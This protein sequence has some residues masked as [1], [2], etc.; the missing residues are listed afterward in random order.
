MKQAM[1]FE[2]IGLHADV[3]ERERYADAAA[4]GGDTGI[5]FGAATGP[6]FT[7]DVL[8]TRH[9]ARRQIGIQLKGQPAHGRLRLI[10][11]LFAPRRK[12]GFETALPD[13]APGSDDV[14]NDVD[15]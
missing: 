1:G 14:G 5:H 7:F 10:G 9:A 11:M 12:R 4:S 6:P 2:G 15:T 13:V 8:A 3:L